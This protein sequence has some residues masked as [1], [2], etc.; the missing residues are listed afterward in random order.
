[1]D[2]VSSTC[3]R[4][5]PLVHF[6]ACSTKAVII[7]NVLKFRCSFLELSKLYKNTVQTIQNSKYKYTHSPKHPHTP[8]LTH[9]KTSYNNHSKRHTP[10]EIVTIQSSTLTIRSPKC[11]WHF[12]PQELHRNSLHLNFQKKSLHINHVSSLHIT[13]LHLFTLIIHLFTLTLQ[14]FTLNISLIYTNTSFLH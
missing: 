2:A 1:M 9:Y 10:N 12:C 14:L 6:T 13:T 3:L 11:M 4:H 7:C 5:Y 8:S